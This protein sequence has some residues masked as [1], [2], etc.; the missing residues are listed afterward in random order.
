MPLPS[1]QP[2]R[3]QPVVDRAGLVTKAWADYFLRMAG[4]QSSDD[5]RA[6]YEA[7][8]ER[9]AE[10]EEGG[11]L[12]FQILGQGSIEVLGIPQPNGVVIITLQNDS[13]EIGNTSYYGTGP[14]GVR[15]W[16]PIAD[17]L[18]VVADELTKAVGGDGITTLGLAD[19]PD[20]GTG[21][22]QKTQFDGKGRKTGT[23]AATTTDL[24]EGT[25]LYYTD[26]RVDARI[27][28]QK[29]QPNGLTPLGSDS[30][31]PSQYL[32]PLAITSTFV[33]GSQAAQLALDAQEGD[34][35]VRTDLNK[36]YIKNAGTT[37]TMADWTELLTPAAPVQSVN[38]QT[39]NVVLT[40]ADVGAAPASAAFPEAPNDGYDYA[41]GS[42]AWHPLTGPLSKYVLLE[43]SP[44]T[45]QLGNPLT[46]QQGRPLY[47]NTPQIPL[48]WIPGVQAEV[49]TIYPLSALP[50]VTPYP[51][52]IYVSGTSG[53]T[54]IIPAY[55][56][57]VNWLRF[58]DNTPVN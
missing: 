15:G 57:G 48:A 49:K 39:G 16:F 26:G 50:P 24:P 23:A 33:V 6:L 27:N 41:R 58:S 2:R 34:V 32:P 44:V 37:G 43:L 40:A 28:L 45:D 9:V 36:N 30:K 42:L 38:G 12:G 22:L 21:T 4:Q 11:T 53:V 3:D 18:S 17:A 10:L 7:L 46:D 14:D 56:N 1:E 51:R 47:F 8:A 25:N 29:G 13:D 20:A 52:E 19:V 35:A 54:G 5:L 55:S 31:I